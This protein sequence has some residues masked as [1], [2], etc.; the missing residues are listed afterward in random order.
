MINSQNIPNIQIWLI[1]EC[2]LCKETALWGFKTNELEQEASYQVLS[3][4]CPNCGAH[5]K[6]G[7]K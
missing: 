6:G 4:Y 2:S 1:S 7:V 5:M 3:T